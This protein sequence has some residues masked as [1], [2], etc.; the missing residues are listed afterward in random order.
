M[1]KYLLIFL[2]LL[3]LL[4]SASIPGYAYSSTIAGKATEVVST[5]SSTTQI[6][7]APGVEITIAGSTITVLGLSSGLGVYIF[8]KSSGKLPGHTINHV[9]DYWV[10]GEPGA[11]TD[12][13]YSLRKGIYIAPKTLGEATFVPAPFPSKQVILAA[14]IVAIITGGTI[15]VWWSAS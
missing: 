7:L 12:V 5:N 8:L 2:T 6:S 14:V 4:V 10:F 3:V 15:Y 1:M 9:I 11:P 13:I